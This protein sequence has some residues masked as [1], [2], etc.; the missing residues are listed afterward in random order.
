MCREAP[1]MP[2]AGVI[3]EVVILDEDGQVLS[4]D[5]EELEGLAYDFFSYLDIEAIIAPHL[6][7]RSV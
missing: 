2:G 7:T 3:S 1:H 5:G 4:A 6:P